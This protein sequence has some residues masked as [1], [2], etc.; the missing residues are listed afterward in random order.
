MSRITGVLANDNSS[1]SRL[2]AITESYGM[3][4]R[5][6]KSID[7]C[8]LSWTGHQ[9]NSESVYSAE[10]I[11]LVTDGSIYLSIEDPNGPRL[12]AH[13]I[14]LHLHA[15]YRK[16]GMD[17]LLSRIDGDFSIAIFDRRER[18]LFLSRDRFGIKP[19]YYTHT[20]NPFVFS[21]SSQPAPLL[22]DCS[23]DS[24]INRAFL[25]QF[26]GLHYR[27]IDNDN[28]ASPFSAVSQIPSSSYLVI[29]PG[30]SPQIKK[31]WGLSEQDEL[32][33]SDAELSDE[34]K[35][36]FFNSVKKRTA[37]LD[38]LA[39]TLSG[40][41][42]SSSVLS[43]YLHLTGKKPT[44]YSATY[45]DPSFDESS[46]IR[47]VSDPH[48]NKWNPIFLDDS[49]QIIDEIDKLVAIHQ[50]PVATTTWLAYHKIVRQC[51][52][53]N[54]THLI[55]GLG[56]DEM[57]A[58]EYEYFPPYFADL[59]QEG[60]SHAYITEVEAWSANHDHPIFRK[61]RSIADHYI[62]TEFVLEQ[63][64]VIRPNLTRMTKYSQSVNKSFYDIQ[65]FKPV[66]DAPFSSY[67]KNRTYQDLTR[68]TLPCCLRA[69]D[70]SS[71][72]FGLQHIN[73]FLD[74][75]L[76]EFA[77]RLP[78]NTKIRNGITKHLLRCSMKG[79]LPEKTRTRI[80][81][82][83]WNAPSQKWFDKAATDRLLD[84]IHSSE[85]Q[86]HGIFNASVI[87]RIISRHHQILNTSEQQE[88]HMMFLWQLAN[89]ISFLRL[90]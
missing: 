58:G 16:F 61:N 13:E 85:M 47:D 59:K 24:S 74:Y 28:N 62:S 15:L 65:Q 33:G 63:P 39:F 43:T 86:K 69:Q 6:S 54:I 88:N 40:G 10:D 38:N 11:L 50:E 77:F 9:D 37:R 35:K 1:L 90:Y 31:Y 29:K 7:D 56:G 22:A 25:A 83:G 27:Y 36:L 60:N 73:P 32:T 76:A 42:D 84:Y 46:E 21:F 53:D 48:T 79:I 67:L 78:G 70:R 87:E 20:T 2:S 71:N 75:K 57:N 49:I 64:G 68:E 4:F 26:L 81:K 12:S 17:G 52:V 5:S 18:S 3:P 34:Y 89:T 72:H 82:T 66:M 51:S 44:A 23:I 19:L 55:G 8:A 14:H 30:S 45:A 80:A 41:L